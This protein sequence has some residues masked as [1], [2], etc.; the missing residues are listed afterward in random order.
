D[1]AGAPVT[2]QGLLVDRLY[3][4]QRWEQAVR[5]YDYHAR[6][7]EPRIARF[8]SV[9]PVRELAN[10]YSYV[11]GRPMQMVDPSGM[12]ALYGPG[13]GFSSLGDYNDPPG[14]PKGLRPNGPSID[15][16]AAFEQNTKELGGHSFTYAPQSFGFHLSQLGTPGGFANALLSLLQGLGAP[17]LIAAGLGMG[18][19]L[20]IGGAAA[21]AVYGLGSTGTFSGA[22]STA[23]DFGGKGFAIGATDIHLAVVGAVVGVPSSVYAYFHDVATKLG[24]GDWGGAT[25]A[26]VVGAILVAVPKFGYYGGGLW[27]TTQFGDW[28]APVLTWTDAASRTHDQRGNELRWAGSVLDPR[29]GGLPPGP[30]G[31]AYSLVGIAGFGIA[32]LAKKALP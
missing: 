6:F 28:G 9:D 1:G 32:G 10:P 4:G 16:L 27:G 25:M 5:L 7:Y 29:S 31:V 15:A 14:A 3:T 11:G 24:D 2:T 13:S 18:A 23:A 21:G 19:A 20:A 12:S 26:A 22:L 17:V 30:F 8:L